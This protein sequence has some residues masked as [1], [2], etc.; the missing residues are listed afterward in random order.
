MTNQGTGRSLEWHRWPAEVTRVLQEAAWTASGSSRPNM[1]VLLKRWAR[2][3]PGCQCPAAGTG[4]PRFSHGRED[5]APVLS[6]TVPHVREAPHGQ[7]SAIPVCWSYT[8]EVPRVLSRAQPECSVGPSPVSALERRSPRRAAPGSRG[9]CRAPRYISG[10][11][12]P[13]PPDAS[14]GRASS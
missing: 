4:L 5:H 13:M 14:R 10:A 8:C 2:H 3:S 1:Q 12:Q 7:G 11:A 9:R 6:C